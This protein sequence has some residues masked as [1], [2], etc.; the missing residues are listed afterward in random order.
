MRARE[1]AV[2]AEGEEHDGWTFEQFRAAAEFASRPRRDTTGCTS[3]PTL[4][5]LAPFIYSGG[6]D[7]FDDDPSP[8]SLAFSEDD[9]RDALDPGARAAARP[10]GHAHRGAARAAHARWSGSSAASSA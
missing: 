3:S 1:L 10:A 2:P 9:T 8:T 4:R 5:G 7:V 6:G